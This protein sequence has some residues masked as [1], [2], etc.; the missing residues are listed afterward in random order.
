M[1]FPD[2]RPPMPFVEIRKLWT[3]FSRLQDKFLTTCMKCIISVASIPS[4]RFA[5]K[6]VFACKNDKAKNAHI[7]GAFA[8]NA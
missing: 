5:D 7:L 2:G 3:P 4:F 1:K 8:P 6:H